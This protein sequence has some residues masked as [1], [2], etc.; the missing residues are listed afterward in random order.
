MRFC[1][2]CQSDITERPNALRCVPCQQANRKAKRRVANAKYRA[3]PDVQEHERRY[4]AE[5]Y[6]QFSA[7]N[8]AARRYCVECQADISGRG[9][10]AL[11]CV[12]CALVHER[13]RDRPAKVRYHLANIDRVREKNTNYA[14][15][16]RAAD[17][18]GSRTREAAYVRQRYASDPAFRARRKASAKLAGPRRRAN[19]VSLLDAQQNGLCGSPNKDT[20]HK[21][22]GRPLGDDSEVDHII[23]LSKGGV[24]HMANLQLLHRF[25]N[26]AARDRISPEFIQVRLAL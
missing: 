12:P 14:R 8:P 24:N 10:R 7:L 3:K 17:L 25:C 23:P 21:G 1:R 20:S 22:C 9:P 13:E 15:A 6:Q 19:L 5:R 18:Q 4:H 11:R 26:R 16:V 2:N